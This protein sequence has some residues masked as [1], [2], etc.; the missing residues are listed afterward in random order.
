VKRVAI[1]RPLAVERDVEIKNVSIEQLPPHGP[2]HL[3][4]RVRSVDLADLPSVEIRS[5]LRTSLPMMTRKSPGS[6]A[7]RHLFR[8]NHFQLRPKART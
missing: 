3:A 6:K 7:L 2:K 1:N 5:K 8:Q 4:P